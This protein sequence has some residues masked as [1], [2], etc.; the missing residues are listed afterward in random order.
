MIPAR[1]TKHAPPYDAMEISSKAAAVINVANKIVFRAINVQNDAS[2]KYD[3][4]LALKLALYISTLRSNINDSHN[5]AAAH[6]KMPR[7]AKRQFCRP[8]SL[9]THVASVQFRIVSTSIN[10]RYVTIAR[11]RRIDATRCISIR[12]CVFDPVQDVNFPDPV[13]LGDRTPDDLAGRT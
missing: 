12:F 7:I 1:R 8:P 2:G 4:P 9:P 3:S 11:N 13:D 5:I 6:E 10:V